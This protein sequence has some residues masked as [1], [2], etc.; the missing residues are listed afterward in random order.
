MC[1]DD[2]FFRAA[3][4]SKFRYFVYICTLFFSGVPTP[5]EGL[6]MFVI[7]PSEKPVDFQRVSFVLFTFFTCESKANSAMCKSNQQFKFQH[8]AKIADNRQK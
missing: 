3:T 8:F 1:N 2:A 5:I 7:V 6:F 4:P